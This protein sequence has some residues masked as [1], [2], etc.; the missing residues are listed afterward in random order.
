MIIADPLLSSLYYHRCK[1]KVFCATHAV[2]FSY[3]TAIDAS[4][5][6]KPF[7][8]SDNYRIYRW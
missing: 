8:E 1:I 7:I 6:K 3:K 4:R 2:R 5:R